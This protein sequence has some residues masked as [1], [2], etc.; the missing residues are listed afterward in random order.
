MCRCL[1]GQDHRQM[2]MQAWVA[3]AIGVFFLIALMS[4][5]LFMMFGPQRAVPPLALLIMR[6]ILALAAGALG[7]VIPGLLDLSLNAPGLVIRATAG[8]ALAVLVYRVNP[9]ALMD[10][11]MTATVTGDKAVIVQSKG[12]NTNIEA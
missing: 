5:A 2:T 3:T 12:D 9:P 10:G 6:T 1:Y 8:L 11:G 7:A 4:T